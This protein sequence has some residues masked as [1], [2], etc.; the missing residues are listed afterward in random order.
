[1]E[2]L[3]ARTDYSTGLFGNENAPTCGNNIYTNRNEKSERVDVAVL[4][5]QVSPEMT[6]TRKCD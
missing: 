5:R 6:T 1:L 4:A 3:I 2:L